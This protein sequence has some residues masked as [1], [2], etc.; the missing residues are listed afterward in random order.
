MSP[1]F[2]EPSR[3]DFESVAKGFGLAGDGGRRKMLMTCG[4][5]WLAAGKKKPSTWEGLHA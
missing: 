2:P 4:E 1:L 3:T 5:W